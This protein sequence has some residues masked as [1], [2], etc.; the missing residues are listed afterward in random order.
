MIMMAGSVEAR[1]HG[2]RVRQTFND[3]FS[4]CICKVWDVDHLGFQP[5]EQGEYTSDMCY[6]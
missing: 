2:T 5:R 6:V 4:P 1:T 3:S